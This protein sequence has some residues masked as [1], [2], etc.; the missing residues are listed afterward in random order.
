M[1]SKYTVWTIFAKIIKNKK[2][3]GDRK[4]SKTKCQK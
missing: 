1:Y 4:R 3:S 2:T